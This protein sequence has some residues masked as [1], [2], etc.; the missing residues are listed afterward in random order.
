[1]KSK[2]KNPGK[3]F[4]VLALF[5]LSIGLIAGVL[6]GLIYIVPEFLKESLG[7]ISLR[8][9][10]VSSVMFWIIIGATGCVYSGMWYLARKPVVKVLSKIQMV[11][12]LIALIGI[13]GSYLTG[14]F[15]GREYWEFNPVW[16]LPIA[17]SWVVFLI[18][19]ISMAKTIKRWPVYVWM[20]L[21]GI[22]FFLF[23]FSENY[24]W[25][26]PYFR[27]N[28]VTDMTIQWKV[29]GS[30]VGSLNQLLYGTSFFLMD[31]I[32][33]NENAKIGFSKLA[34]GM[35]FL[36]LTNLMFNWGHHIYNL[37]TDNYI[38]YV[39]YI[40]SMTE[41]IFFVKIIYN[42]KKQLT[43]FKTYY[44]FFPY[45]F[46]M[47]TEFWVFV[48]MGQAILMS[49]PVLNLYT[50]GT[51]VTVA[52]SMGTTIGINSMIL[53]AAGFMFLIPKTEQSNK[54]ARILSITFWSLQI[55]LALLFVS[56]DI[57][58]FKKGQWQLDPN[59]SSFGTMME[60]LRPWFILLVI[61]GI[62]VMSSFAVFIVYLLKKVLK[63]GK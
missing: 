2:V 6:S 53:L 63:N 58:G 56:L 62:G 49:I 35:Y 32:S 60:T 15:G 34:F 45:R 42:W 47:A 36:G 41:W 57:A 55:S 20:W 4:I 30:L 1:M 3:Q 14:N 19:F 31:R 29:N 23:I 52:H 51:H 26:F 50:H 37:P 21:T 17:L 61:S 8:P 9:F 54:P 43:E 40:V 18:G 12:W 22:V 13:Y 39:A 59:Q 11:L 44:S 38:R 5:L 10:H 48:N 7:F 33:K 27:E 16:A 28:F 24:L 46:L 25:I